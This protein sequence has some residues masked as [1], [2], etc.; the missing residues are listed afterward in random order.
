MA[1]MVTRISLSGT[2]GV[3]QE[4]HAPWLEEERDTE[5]TGSVDIPRDQPCTA[6]RLKLLTTPA[7]LVPFAQPF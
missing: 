6:S 2:G 7:R 1:R 4:L 3:R 5:R